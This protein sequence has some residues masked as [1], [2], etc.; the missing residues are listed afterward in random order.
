MSL[1]EE[2]ASMRSLLSHWAHHGLPKSETEAHE[3]VAALQPKE[4]AKSST[5][6]GKDS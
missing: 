1:Q 6:K 3:Q 5:S 2:V 4:E